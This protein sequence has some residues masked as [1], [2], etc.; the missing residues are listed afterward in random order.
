MI[1]LN[2]V[3]LVGNLARDPDLRHTPSG[4]PVTEFRL[5]VS[6]SYTTSAGDKHDRTCFIDVVSWR[7]LAE[8]CAEYL[9][10]GSPVFVEGR[11]EQDTWTT[12]EGQRRS[13]IRVVAYSVQFIRREVERSASGRH[14]HVV[15]KGGN[16]IRDID[17]GDDLAEP[18][19]REDTGHNVEDVGDDVTL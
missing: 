3:F 7:K 5:A 12:G 8:S 19:E 4:T 17:D 15:E 11:L 18:P 1:T 16:T 9:K 6:D 13:R 14:I 2:K 10:K